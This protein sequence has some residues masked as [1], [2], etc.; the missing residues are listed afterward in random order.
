MPVILFH[1]E[2]DE[3]IYYNSSI[4]LKGIMKETDTLITLK[5]HGHNG[6]TDNPEYIRMIENILK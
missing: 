2:E 5:G 1:G 6:I 3:V 4:K